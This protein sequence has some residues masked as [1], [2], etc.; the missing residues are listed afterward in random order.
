[1]ANFFQAIVDA[2]V[3]GVDAIGRWLSAFGTWLVNH[4]QVMMALAVALV[5]PLFSMILL[6]INQFLSEGSGQMDGMK[7]TGGQVV[8]QCNSALGQCVYAISRANVFFP[9]D[10]A[11]IAGALLCTLWIAAC[12]YRLIKSY[13]P[14]MS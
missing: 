5:A 2:L 9:V 8:G 1:M 10:H 6:L 3:N 12:I 13:V 4:I 11:F 7:A 14:T